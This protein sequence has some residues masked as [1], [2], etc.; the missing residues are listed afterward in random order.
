MLSRPAYLAQFCVIIKSKTQKMNSLRKISLS[1]L[2]AV[3]ILSTISCQ[4]EPL[5]LNKKTS[6]PPTMPGDYADNPNTW[7]YPY[8]TITK[9]TFIP[10]NINFAHTKSIAWRIEWPE[11]SEGVDTDQIP[12]F[13]ATSKGTLNSFDFLQSV[14]LAT[15]KKINFSLYLDNKVETATNVSSLWALGESDGVV[16]VKFKSFDYT[17]DA[18]ESMVTERPSLFETYYGDDQ[19]SFWEAEYEVGDFF[20]F[21]T[22]T[23][24]PQFGGIRI[25]S[26]SPRIIEVYLAVPNN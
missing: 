8:P 5:Y 23:D 11:Y 16:D 10:N 18:I 2:G 9:Q 19:N 24:I 6:R 12:T 20:I 15:K 17:I 26:E 22:M 25:V 1:L 13:F 7:D 21:K 14:D 3:I 4:E